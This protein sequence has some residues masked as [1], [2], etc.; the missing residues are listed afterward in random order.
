MQLLGHLG[1]LF[2]NLHL[3]SSGWG[4]E[5][6]NYARLR[7]DKNKWYNLQSSFRRDQSFF[8]YDLLANPLNPPPLPAPGGST[9]SIPV[10]TSPHEFDTTRRMSDVDLTL[11]PQSAVS[12]RGGYS[13]NNMTGPSYSSIHEGTE[14]SLLQ[15]WNTTMNSYRV[16]VD[17]RI[18]PRT[19]LSYDQFLDYYKGDTDY[20]LNPINEA[21][22][23]TTPTSSVSLGLSFDPAN[24]TPCAVVPPAASL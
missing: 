14:A 12:F 5:P 18:A 3:N 4:G 8:D 13:H 22:L 11:L 19:V 17:F 15:N 24:K 20:Q 1:L 10:L 9:P 6:N 21:F 2:D 23:P 7:V 16:G